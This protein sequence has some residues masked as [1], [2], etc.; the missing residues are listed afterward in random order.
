M[1][2]ANVPELDRLHQYHG[3]IKRECKKIVSKLDIR[4]IPY[5][6][7]EN[8]EV[9]DS[10]RWL[11]EPYEKGKSNKDGW[12]ISWNRSSN[13]SNGI[14]NDNIAY[15]LI[16]NNKFLPNLN[17]LPFIKDVLC[18]LNEKHSIHM[19]GLSLLKSG[20]HIYPH[21]DINGPKYGL[22]TCNY[23]I[24]GSSGNTLTIF[25][26]EDEGLDTSSL[27]TLGIVTH[28]ENKY[29]IFDGCKLHQADNASDQDRLALFIAFTLKI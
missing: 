10:Q 9:Q 28:E 4:R 24:F 12:H 27:E 15:P 19:S 29:V 25:D 13:P 11:D 5:R 7:E 2:S 21:V 22:A 14:I 26:G 8:F 6:G 3:Q 23:C 20:G 1:L 16:I 18:K 17:K